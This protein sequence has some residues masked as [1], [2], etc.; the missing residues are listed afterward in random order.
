MSHNEISVNDLSALHGAI[1]IDVRE[2]D[3]YG[4]GH[5]PGAVNIP[6]AD[7][8]ERSAE[9]R[10][11]DTVYVI[12]QSGRRST[13]ACDALESLGITSVN[14]AGGTTAWI[15]ASLPVQQ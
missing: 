4:G 12:C 15:A 1:V 13:F 5:V 7:V 10:G 8:R 9:L 11:A 6:L 2:P 14:V 3:E